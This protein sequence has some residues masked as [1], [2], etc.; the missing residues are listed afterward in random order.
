MFSNSSNFKTYIKKKASSLNIDINY[1]YQNY[2]LQCVAQ[3]ISKSKY[4]DELVYKGG[5]VLSSIIGI[6]T[7]STMDIDLTIKSKSFS[8]DDLYNM[9]KEICSIEIECPFIFSI[10]HISNEMNTKDEN[11]YKVILLAKYDNLKFNVKIDIS[12][13]SLIYPKDINYVAHGSMIDK[14][15]NILTYPIENIIAEK[16][17]T[18]IDRGITNSRM[19]DFYDLFIL[20]SN[21]KE[22]N[23]N[24]KLLIKTLH[25]VAKNRNTIGTLNNS[26]K[27]INEIEISTEFNKYWLNYISDINIAAKTI[28]TKDI[29]NQLR[30]VANEY[31]DEYKNK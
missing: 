11:G 17:E 24:R 30:N 26:V 6:E 25:E 23:I 8:Y 28:E 5:F 16:Y 12:C 22:Y 7:R 15:I 14:D 1:G 2:L 21:E 27:V 19:R 9:F 4:K 13:G 18:L 10:D 31:I 3:K 20:L 29:F